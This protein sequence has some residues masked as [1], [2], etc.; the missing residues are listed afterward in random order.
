MF[1]GLMNLKRTSFIRRLRP[2]SEEEQETNPEIQLLFLFI[3][4]ILFSALLFPYFTRF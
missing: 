4:F 3:L 2:S 1:A